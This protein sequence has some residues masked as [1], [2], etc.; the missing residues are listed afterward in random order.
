MRMREGALQSRR[1]TLRI[2]GVCEVDG[3]R[4]NN[5]GHKK[6][7]DGMRHFKSG[8]RLPLSLNL[9]T[10]GY[11]RRGNRTSI[12]RSSSI[13]Q[14]VYVYPR[15]HGIDRPGSALGLAPRPRSAIGR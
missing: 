5:T 6:S 15:I 2:N 14:K 7:R 13:R 3:R 8:H 1:M 9:M 12:P 4:A 11:N 10:G